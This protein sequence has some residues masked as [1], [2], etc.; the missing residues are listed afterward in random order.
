MG[1]ELTVD[2]GLGITGERAF[3]DPGAVASATVY[4]EQLC[5]YYVW[6]VQELAT[7]KQAAPAASNGLELLIG[8]ELWR[9]L[10]RTTK[11]LKE[12]SSPRGGHV[13]SPHGE[14]APA[15]PK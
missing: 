1:E 10:S 11:K 7:M 2:I 14:G 8:R 5:E 12:A 9:K 6:D 15:W 13:G 4:M 3:L